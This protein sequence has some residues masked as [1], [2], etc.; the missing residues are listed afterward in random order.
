MKPVY[1]LRIASLLT[2]F[3]AVTH[4]IGGVFGRPSPGAA[5]AAVSM[6]KANQFAILGVTRSYWNFYRGFGLAVTIFLTVEAVVFWQL[7]SL[8]KSDSLR[9]RPIYATFLVG[10]AAMAANSYEYFF[11]PPVICEILI[12]LC[13][14]LAIATSKPAASR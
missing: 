6:M 5:Q 2:L 7:G 14:A 9:Q 3:H 8:A 10:Y 12:A 4:T 13:L 1:F 11:A